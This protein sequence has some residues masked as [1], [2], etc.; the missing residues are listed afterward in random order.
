MIYPCKLH[1][2]KK[3]RPSPVDT[4]A[5]AL[6]H[7]MN[8]QTWLYSNKALLRDSFRLQLSSSSAVLWTVIRK[9]LFDNGGLIIYSTGKYRF[10]RKHLSPCSES[11]GIILGILFRFG[12]EI[13][14]ILPFVY[15]LGKSPMIFFFLFQTV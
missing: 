11:I 2:E 4:K 13:Q 5:W 10:K 3:S 6:C 15:T 14:F 8:F 7:L 12:R 1:L 9:C